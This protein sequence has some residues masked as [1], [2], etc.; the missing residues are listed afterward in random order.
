MKDAAVVHTPTAILFSVEKAFHQII[1]LTLKGDCRSP[2]AAFGAPAIA[3]HNG[4]SKGGHACRASW[5]NR[6]T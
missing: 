6:K 3:V 1:L 5:I 4:C 2:G